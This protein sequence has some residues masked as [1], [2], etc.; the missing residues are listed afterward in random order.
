MS[1]DFIGLHK[2]VN[3]FE[4]IMCVGGGEGWSFRGMPLAFAE[5]KVS[6][7]VSLVSVEFEHL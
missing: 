6:H 4:L 1:L 2:I 7:C 5:V 3:V